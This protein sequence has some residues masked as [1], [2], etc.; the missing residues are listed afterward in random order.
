MQHRGKKIQVVNSDTGRIMSKDTTPKRGL[1]Q[2]KA[3]YANMPAN[4]RLR[5]RISMLDESIL[6]EGERH[7]VN[8][9]K[10][11]LKHEEIYGEGWFSDRIDE[12]ANLA[13]RFADKTVQYAKVLAD[14]AVDT[15]HK[16]ADKTVEY[17]NTLGNTALDLTNK[18][19]K[20][21][22]TVKDGVLIGV[23][24]MAKGDF[25]RDCKKIHEIVRQGILS[26][27]KS[28]YQFLEDHPALKILIELL[29]FH[30]G[31]IFLAA[32]DHLEN[33]RLTEIEEEEEQKIKDATHERYTQFG[34]TN[35]P[36]LLFYFT[37]EGSFRL[38]DYQHDL[39]E[40]NRIKAAFDE[41]EKR[42]EEGN[43]EEDVGLTEYERD[44]AQY[45]RERNAFDKKA[46]KKNKK[47]LKK[48]KNIINEDK[49][50]INEDKNIINE[51]IFENLD[52]EVEKIQ[53]K[54]DLIDDQYIH[55]DINGTPID[56]DEIL[57]FPMTY[58]YDESNKP[59]Y[60]QD[61]LI[62]NG[63]AGVNFERNEFGNTYKNQEPY[64]FLNYPINGGNLGKIDYSKRCY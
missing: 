62:S 10:K 6:G 7:I 64:A 34:G 57:R 53:D 56:I 13:S 58:N 24:Y 28:T 60:L 43:P 15:S 50:I 33:Q 54:Q 19:E 36:N 51:D 22:N 9:A 32:L 46:N 44:L 26:G 23:D 18:F 63:V 11:L 25:I 52:N 38:E 41:Q 16:L 27:V 35:P 45:E 3:I 20:A 17:A 59:K 12:A 5:H 40:Y 55:K 14:T 49:N 39:S 2:I 37:S 42:R 61:Y 21:Y 48:E 29:P 31:T 1:N 47:K 4:H 8:F 30:L